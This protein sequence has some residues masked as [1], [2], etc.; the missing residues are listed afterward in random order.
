MGETDDSLACHDPKMDMSR[1]PGPIALVGSGEYL[2]EMQDVEAGLLKG[3]PPRY[4]Q[5]ATAAAVDGPDAVV[6]WHRL[7]AQQGERLGVEVVAVPVADRNDAMDPAMADLCRGAGLIYLSGGKP[8]YLAATLGGTLVWDAIVAAWQGGSALA[9]CS[10]GAMVMAARVPSFMGAG[11][12]TPGLSLLPHMR[13]IPHFD[14]YVPQLPPLVAERILAP[15]A[16]VTLI[17]VDEMTAIVGGPE[18]WTV[19]GRGR[20]VLVE[21]QGQREFRV[22]ETFRVAP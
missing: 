10:A 2:P 22:G 18:T 3:R 8:A 13:V 16:G 20:A 17:G 4:V 7:G 12:V 11:E 19:Q 6:R 9:G 21:A 5:L 14:V 1:S 15:E